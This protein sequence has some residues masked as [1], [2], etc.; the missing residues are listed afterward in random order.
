[1]RAL[2]AGARTIIR[3]GY[4]DDSEHSEALSIRRKE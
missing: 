1:M 4:G 2:A 3:S